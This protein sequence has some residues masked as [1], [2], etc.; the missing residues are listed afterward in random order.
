MSYKRHPGFKN[1]NFN[2]QDKFFNK[3]KGTYLKFSCLFCSREYNR[4]ITNRTFDSSCRSCFSVSPLEK[5]SFVKN[6]LYGNYYCTRR[7]CGYRWSAKVN[8]TDIIL[9]TPTCKPCIRLTKVTQ[10]E[11]LNKQVIF[12]NI[13]TYVCYQC[14]ISK[15]ITNN[16]QRGN[17]ND[18]FIYCN[19]CD[20]RLFYKNCFKKI[21]ILENSSNFNMRR[22]IIKEE[23][24]PNSS[25]LKEDEKQILKQETETI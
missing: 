21:I 12:N 1:Q 14:K 2:F 13:S 19:S 4:I 5:F 24:L 15:K 18:G 22:R 7:E 16:G 23:Q 25:T 8:F 17:Q 6:V 11:Y 10:I 9:N 20:G 3:Q